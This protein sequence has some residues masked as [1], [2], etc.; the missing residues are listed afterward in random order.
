M[1]LI[2]EKLAIPNNRMG[3]ESKYG[4]AEL[5][6]TFEEFFKHCLED[7]SPD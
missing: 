4:G 6:E 5:P 2:K 7:A 1:I 3:K